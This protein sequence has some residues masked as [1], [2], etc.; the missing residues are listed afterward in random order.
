MVDDQTF[1]EITPAIPSGTVAVLRD[2]AGG[3]FEVLMLRR[4]AHEHDTFSGMWVFPGGKVEDEDRLENDAQEWE[5]ARVAALRETFEEAGIALPLSSLVPVDRWEPEPRSG[6][7]RRFSAW[8]FVAPANEGAVTVDGH[9]IREHDWVTPSE[10][11][12][13]HAADEMGIVPPTWVTLL[14]LSSFSSV[15]EVLAWAETRTPEDYRS[16]ITTLDDQQ[17]IFWHGDELYDG[18]PGGRHRLFMEPGAW[19]YER[20]V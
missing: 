13:R 4:S 10:A 8:I 9:E 15:S 5:V 17:V 2:R 16:R 14:K 12:A 3:G 7:R 19:S 11:L 18:L 20:N 6:P 1:E